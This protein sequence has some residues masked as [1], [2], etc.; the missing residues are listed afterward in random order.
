MKLDVD[1]IPCD[2][3]LALYGELVMLSKEKR[4]YT[5]DSSLR[6]CTS[7]DLSEHFQTDVV[8]YIQFQN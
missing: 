2:L 3:L 5:K 7:T 4:I 1:D 6:L 8:L